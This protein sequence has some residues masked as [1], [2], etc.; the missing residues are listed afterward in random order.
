MMPKAPGSEVFSG[1]ING[2]NALTLRAGRLAVDSRYARIMRVMRDSEQQRPRLRRLG[3]QLG[4][5]YTPT[6]LALAIAAGVGSG[7]PV[8]FLAVLVVATPCPLLI[9]I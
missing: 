3:D 7:E 6:A 8:R 4:A 1:A 5:W 9:A 2:E